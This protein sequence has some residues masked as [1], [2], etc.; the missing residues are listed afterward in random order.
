M[1]V[2]GQRVKT[3]YIL[4]DYENVQP[5][6]IS[7]LAADHFR[8]LAFI[9]SNQTKVKL[10]TAEA[11][12]KMGGRAEYIRILGNGRNALDF[13]IAYYIGQ[14]AV[15]EPEAYFHIISGDTGFDPLIEHARSKSLCVARWPDIV[16]IPIVKAALTAD[17]R[18]RVNLVVENLR[19]R[20]DSRP[21][22]VK[23]LLTTIHAIFNKQLSE[24]ALT[25]LL[26]ELQN[27]KFVA[28][29]ETKVSYALPEGN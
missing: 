25:E 21:K 5:E 16:E 15:R 19:L 11:L 26:V 10:G 29:S 24:A 1:R 7:L 18:N 4:I 12:Q 28:V 14:I 3:N 13:H 2:Q 6:S 8:V 22:R 23:T 20:G 9:G 17:I 27:R